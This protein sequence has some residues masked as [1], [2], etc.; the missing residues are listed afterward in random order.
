MF[1]EEINNALKFGY[2]FKIL[3]GYL[4]EKDFIFKDYINDLYEIKKAHHKDHPMYLIS[5]L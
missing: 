1:S 2:S 3:R 4:F 5:K